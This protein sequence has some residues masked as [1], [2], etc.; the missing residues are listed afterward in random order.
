[1][2][3][4]L[5]IAAAMVFVGCRPRINTE[6]ERAALLQTDRDWSTVAH[7]GSDT[8]RIVGYWSD[9]ARVNPPDMAVIEGKAAIR[10]FVAASLRTPGFSVSWEPREAIVSPDGQFGYTTGVNSFTVPGPQGKLITIA[11]NYVTVWRKGPDGRW[12]CVIDFW[13]STPTP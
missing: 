12:R 7:A 4:R 9:D 3:S 10:N 2:L 8:D 1:M 5:V 13:N 11:G 6:A